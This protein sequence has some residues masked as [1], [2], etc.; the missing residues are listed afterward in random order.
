MAKHEREIKGKATWV[1][2]EP[3]CAALPNNAGYKEIGY[4]AKIGIEGQMGQYVRNA[5]KCIVFP[6]EPE[7]ADAGFIELEKLVN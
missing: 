1:L 4:C 3:M 6:T 2:A 7:A 5:G